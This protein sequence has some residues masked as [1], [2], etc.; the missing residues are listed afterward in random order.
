MPSL[1]AEKDAKLQLGQLSQLAMHC[2]SVVIPW[3]LALHAPLA[4]AADALQ[5]AARLG[6]T[7]WLGLRLAAGLDPS[8]ARTTAGFE[9]T[10][11]SQDPCELVAE[12]FEASGHLEQRQ[13]RW[14]LTALGI[15]LADA[16]A[17]EF[18]VL[19]PVS[20]TS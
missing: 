3:S 8:E 11:D 19:D 1:V 4:A 5:P 12:K 14:R 9:S 6:E 20:P 7:W 17:S 13:G 15:P 16:I 10:G 2:A 18:L